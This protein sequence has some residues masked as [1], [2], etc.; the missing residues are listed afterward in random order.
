MSSA[1]KFETQHSFHWY[2]KRRRGLGVNLN[3]YWDW[4]ADLSVSLTSGQ[5]TLRSIFVSSE[6][7]SSSIVWEKLYNGPC[8]RV[9]TYQQAISMGKNFVLWRPKIIFSEKSVMHGQA[10]VPQNS[11]PHEV[12]LLYG[13]FLPP[14]RLFCW[15]THTTP[16]PIEVCC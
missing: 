1:L 11:Q 9:P 3:L 6:A 7:D 4:V 13:S 8:N 15:M 14:V 16:F 10:L 5:L 2:L 12:V